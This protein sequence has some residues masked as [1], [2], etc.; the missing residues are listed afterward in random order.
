MGEKKGGMCDWPCLNVSGGTLEVV[1]GPSTLLSGSRDGGGVI[2]MLFGE[3]GV[4]EFGTFLFSGWT[5]LERIE[6][7]STLV[8]IGSY[9]FFKCVSLLS[10]TIP[11]SVT[12]LGDFSFANCGSLRAVTFV[13]SSE[14]SEVGRGAFEKC[15]ELSLRLP[16]G[17]VMRGLELGPSAVHDI[18]CCYNCGE[19]SGA[20]ICG[21][22]T[23]DD[24][25]MAIEDASN[26]YWFFVLL[27][28]V[29]VGYV[30]VKVRRRR[31]R[32]RGRQAAG[33][34]DEASAGHPTIEGFYEYADGAALYEEPLASELISSGASFYGGT[35]ASEGG[36]EGFDFCGAALYD[37]AS[38]RNTDLE[39]GVYDNAGEHGSDD[40]KILD[41]TYEEGY[42]EI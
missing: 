14:L 9:A 16:G 11:L 32:T 29:V 19:L 36:G 22:E 23:R 25:D 8:E 30:F 35:D 21:D 6:L 17:A 20:P 7:P 15:G 37:C 5:E 12:T 41:K 2:S 33:T 28:C 24:K 3:F 18:G 39:E 27:V 34:E 40:T 13:E 31:D 4:E 38:G 10:I 1:S 42:L 26:Y